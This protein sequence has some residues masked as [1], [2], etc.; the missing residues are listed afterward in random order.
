M[1]AQQRRE[2]TYPKRKPTVKYDVALAK[3]FEDYFKSKW[4]ETMFYTPSDFIREFKINRHLARYYLM[5]MVW[6]KRLF[7]VKFSNKTYYRKR[8]PLRID[9]YKELVWFGVEVTV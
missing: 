9:R 7:R 1:L 4:I 3:Q 8:D 2:V 6:D 5:S